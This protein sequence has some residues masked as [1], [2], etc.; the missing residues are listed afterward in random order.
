MTEVLT[1][2]PFSLTVSGHLGAHQ[3]RD[4]SYIVSVGTEGAVVHAVHADGAALNVRGTNTQNIISQTRPWPERVVAG[5]ALI[6]A[7]VRNPGERKEY[8]DAPGRSFCGRMAAFCFVPYAVGEGLLRPPAIGDGILH[9]AFL[10]KTPILESQVNVGRLPSV[11]DVDR[12]DV[13]WSGWGAGKPDIS[14][15][16]ALLREFG[17][18]CYDG[19]NTDTRTPD[20]QH[21]GYGVAYA[22]I[23]SQAM[24]QLC[25]TAPIEQKR[26]LALA[27]VQRGLDLVGAWA[28]GR[29][30]HVV[31]GHCLGRKALIVATGHLLGI[32]AI[33][34]PN[35]LLG[36]AF[37]EDSLCVDGNWFFP[38]WTARWAFN[39]GSA[40]H[41][42]QSCELPPEMWGS[43]ND[44]QH[45]SWAWCVQGYLAPTIG[46]SVGTA[47]AL[48]L[49][50]RT[51]EMGPAFDRMVDQF[52]ASP[53]SGVSA[54]LSSIGINIS[55]GRDHSLVRGAGFC[56]EAWRRHAS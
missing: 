8:W 44:A 11:I 5:D 2:G 4:G 53:P 54:R 46:A 43:V 21:P 9:R 20:L 15:L 37:A 38:E 19:W 45:T 40:S 30:N 47:L 14:Y 55:W 22:S 34:N 39:G 49:L 29:R 27:V 13:D 33:A 12:L 28:D 6:L 10:R 17:G 56:S 24:L 35:A 51:A 42:G 26:P 41:T 31:G 52:M 50:N 18:E 36:K 16:T 48:R 25:S 7:S 1:A 3:T 23:V 32:E